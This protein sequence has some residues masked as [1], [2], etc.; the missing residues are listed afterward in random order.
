[1]KC[2]EDMGRHLVATKRIEPGD[3]IAVEKPYTNILLYNFYLTHCHHCLQVSYNLI[4]CYECPLT[5][6]CSKTCRD[7]AWKRYH[8]YECS[9]LDTLHSIES[10]KLQLL[11]LRVVLC[12]RKDFPQILKDEIIDGE[13]SKYKSER[14]K[15]IHDLVTNEEHR[16]VN[17]LFARSTVAAV[18]FH[19][20][21][22]TSFFDDLNDGI[23]VEEIKKCTAGL[24]LRHLQTAPSNMHE[25]SEFQGNI[26]NGKY[27][28]SNCNNILILN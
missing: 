10:T 24:L 16:P 19:L 27:A 20:L 3:I 7:D 25:I 28:I 17:E 26:E 12:A 9:L 6:Y 11:A 23:D 8:Q 13:D 1:M 18:L 15:E 21:H 22:S 2:T 5:L 14:Y 4:P